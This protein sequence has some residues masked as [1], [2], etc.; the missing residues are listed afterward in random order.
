[1][2]LA[3]DIGG[4]KISLGI[5]ASEDSSRA[6]LK[7]VEDSFPSADFDS[8]ESLIS[9]YLKTNSS[10]KIK[11]AVFA[12]AGPV[13]RGRSRITNLP[14]I[15]DEKQLQLELN[16]TSVRLLNDLEAIAHAVPFMP[17]DEKY[18]L[19]QGIPAPGGN[20]GI[21]APG[22]GLGESFLTMSSSGYSAHAA[23]G[24]HADFAPTN[25][26]EVDLL[27][28]L[29]SDYE[30]VS[31]ERVCSGIGLWNIYA[32]LRSRS[33]LE[34]PSW[35][36]ERLTAAQDPTAV[37]VDS[38]LSKERSCELC[39]VSLNMFV[40]ILGAEAGN[41]ALK[42]MATAGIF[43]GGGIPPRILEIL[44]NGFFMMAF[45]NKG[46]MSE[47]MARIPVYVILNPQIARDGAARIGFGVLEK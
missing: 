41:L 16:L 20:M 5:Y 45:K 23:E 7:L 39:I 15:L 13:V 8:L 28:F 32:Y 26:E 14:W 17:P 27:R 4:T 40:S 43:L 12:V 34:E 3:G 29:L 24:G 2:F 21:I 36:T 11:K 37:I 10:L 33:N 30:R 38:A 9:E 6:P 47:L 44:E 42:V 35:L 19:N 18:V 25:Q 46:R 1:M 31:Y 22:T